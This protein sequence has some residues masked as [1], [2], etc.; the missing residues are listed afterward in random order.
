MLLVFDIGN[1]Q[2]VVGVFDKDKLVANWRLATDRQK[3]ADEYGILVKGLFTDRKLE[4]SQVR[5]AIISS[6]V[7]PLA[8]LFEQMIKKYFGVGVLMIG[9]GVKTGLVIKMED[10]REVGADLI[11]NAVAG[12]KIYGPPL[13]IVDF[14]TATTFCAIAP[15]GDYLGGALF[16]GLAIASEAL[17]QRTAKLPWVELLKPKTVIGKNTIQAIQSGLIYGYVGMVES[18]I[19]RIKT[20]MSCNPKVIATGGLSEIIANETKLIDLMNPHL[21]LEGLRLIYEMNIF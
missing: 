17:F 15:S 3:T 4:T 7:P 16:P 18:M 9:P 5:G 14:G 12:V 11:V 10:P 19:T 1:T 13:L 21:T 2:I 20:E 6:V 8:G